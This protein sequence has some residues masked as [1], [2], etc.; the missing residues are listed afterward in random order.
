VTPPPTGP[1]DVDDPNAVEQE[2]GSLLGD[3]FAAVS[4]TDEPPAYD[5]LHDLFT[6]GGRLIRTSGPAPEVTNVEQFVT[7]RQAL[8]HSGVLRSFQELELM[9]ITEI[10][11]R[12]A[13]RFSSYIKHGVMDGV[14][15]EGRGV[16]STQ[17]IETAGG[18]RISS[19]AWDDERPGL[20][21]PER[22]G[23]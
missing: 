17:L 13:H 11:G 23:A 19:M 4:F 21:I 5:R 1:S 14:P 7:S 9:G 18:W 3:F 15:F 8:V 22:Y 16:I 12:V 2:L 20:R 10:F 6:E